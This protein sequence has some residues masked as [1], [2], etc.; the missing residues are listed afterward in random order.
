MAAKVTERLIWRQWS[1]LNFGDCLVAVKTK[2]SD[3]NRLEGYTNDFSAWK[4]CQI[5]LSVHTGNF[6]LNRIY[7]EY[8]C[9]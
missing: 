7:T 5:R 3:S 6:A 9:H 1:L 8:A 4:S 2:R